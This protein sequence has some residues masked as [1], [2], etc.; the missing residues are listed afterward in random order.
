MTNLTQLNIKTPM[1][2]FNTGKPLPN[3]TFDLA[4]ELEIKND[5]DAKERRSEIPDL[6]IADILDT[7]FDLVPLPSK[8]DFATYNNVLIDIRNAKKKK[9]NYIEIDKGEL[10]K[11]KTIFEKGLV[12]KP[13]LNR[14]TGFIIEVLEQT[15]ANIVVKN[16][17]Q[18][19]T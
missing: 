12:D 5:K 10:E 9:Q 14:R 18:P 16:I 13:E 8:S 17:T 11:L 1:C 7:C 19:T 15:I 4:I 6:T 3:L 2:D